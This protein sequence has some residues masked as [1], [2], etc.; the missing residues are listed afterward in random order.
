MSGCRVTSIVGSLQC[1]P[2]APWVAA[3]SSR[4]T[5]PNSIPRRGGALLCAL[6]S[7][8]TAPC[9]GSDALSWVYDEYATPY[10]DGATFD[11]ISVGAGFACGVTTD[12]EILCWGS[13]DDEL[14]I[15]SDFVVATHEELDALVTA[16]D[17]QRAAMGPQKSEP[18]TVDATLTPI[19]GSILGD[20]AMPDCSAAISTTL[21]GAIAGNNITENTADNGGVLSTH[22][23][24]MSDNEQPVELTFSGDAASGMPLVIEAG[25]L[26]RGD[27]VYCFDEGDAALTTSADGSRVFQFRITSVADGRDC[28]APRLEAT[29]R[30]CKNLGVGE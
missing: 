14:A 4:S 21:V 6:H 26:V 2:S 24:R 3:G 27:Y 30:G 28:S 18:G 23:F 25:K 19:T 9:I 10:P 8:G 17:D 22:W 12:Q 15:P 16:A 13:L 7:S 20:A 1:G 11:G 5:L 29:I